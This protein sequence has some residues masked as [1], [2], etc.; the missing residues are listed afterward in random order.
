MRNRKSTVCF[1]GV[2]LS[3]ALSKMPA[4][5]GRNRVAARAHREPVAE[6]V[7]SLVVVEFHVL[8]EVLIASGEAAAQFEL[9]AHVFTARASSI[10]RVFSLT[11]F[12]I[13]AP[14]A[15]GR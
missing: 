12:A 9:G 6:L 15:S 13:Y 11:V 2:T 1:S 8:H 5:W 10:E 4:T 7:G 14:P 3:R